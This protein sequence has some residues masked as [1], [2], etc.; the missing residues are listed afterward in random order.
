ML[1]FTVDFVL[2]QIDLALV[3]NK[4]NQQPILQPL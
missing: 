3:T 4:E 2:A 1:P